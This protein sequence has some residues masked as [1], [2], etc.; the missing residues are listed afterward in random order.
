MAVDLTREWNSVAV[1]GLR[2]YERISTRR[3]IGPDMATF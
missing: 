3:F 1:P 2:A